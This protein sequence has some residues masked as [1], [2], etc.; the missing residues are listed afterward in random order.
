MTA[1]KH[2]FRSRPVT[3]SEH[4][5]FIKS[6]VGAVGHT[7]ICSQKQ[8]CQN[9]SPQMLNAGSTSHPKES[10]LNRC[11]LASKIC[12]VNLKVY[13]SRRWSNKGEYDGNC[14][15]WR[16]CY[17]FILEHESGR[18]RSVKFCC[19]PTDKLTT[20][21][22]WLHCAIF[23]HWADTRLAAKKEKKKENGGLWLH[24]SCCAR[25][26][27]MVRV[28]NSSNTKPHPQTYPQQMT[29]TLKLPQDSEPDLTKQWG[30]DRATNNLQAISYW[31]I[32][33]YLLISMGKSLVSVVEKARKKSFNSA[34]PLCCSVPQL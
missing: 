12:S 28:W 21:R 33:M 10:N 3:T 29:R 11:T 17:K 7:C 25:C 8:Y 30:M 32:F 31:Y 1:D 34:R 23:C 2:W 6:P 26:G 15:F 5:F 27:F 16:Q 4:V 20:L 19:R 9:D 22:S 18:G 14:I 13:T 24:L